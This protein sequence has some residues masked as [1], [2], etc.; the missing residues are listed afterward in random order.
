M[1]TSQ[2]H[3][4]F[5]CDSAMDFLLIEAVSMLS[6]ATSSSQNQLQSTGS[7][8]LTP[9]ETSSDE[10]R[11]AAYFKLESL[12]FR[13]GLGLAEK[14]TRDRPRFSDNL[15]IVKF[16]CKDFWLTV[17]NKQI[18]NLKTNHRGVY[19]L[20]DNNFKWFQRMAGAS[21]AE[22]AQLAFP[23]AAFPC[24]LIRGALSSLGVSSVVLAEVSA[25]PQ[26]TFQIKFK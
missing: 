25:L 13:V 19:V 21:A 8:T 7:L 14:A 24:G 11:E 23:H 22:T 26:C 18:D 10:D 12:G 16:I 17:F 1:D 15:D 4:T 6:L 20:T 2:Q 3:L 9:A 5:V